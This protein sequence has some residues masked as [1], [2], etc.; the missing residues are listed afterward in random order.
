MYPL[1][2]RKVYQYGYSKPLGFQFS[3]SKPT[4][5]D[6]ELKTIKTGLSW[7]PS[8][9]LFAIEGSCFLV[10][11]LLLVDHLYRKKLNMK[12]INLCRQS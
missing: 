7:P 3:D 6:S 9:S 12:S 10:Q 8:S 4:L 2:K 1:G 5:G 11:S